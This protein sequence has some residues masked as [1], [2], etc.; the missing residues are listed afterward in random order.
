MVHHFVEQP[1]PDISICAS[2]RARGGNYERGEG[3]F[4]TISV[5]DSYADFDPS[6][7]SALSK[8]AQMA[9]GDFPVA[10]L[11]RYEPSI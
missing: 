5:K 4:L 2:S 9:G 8:I 10:N 6:L 1:L 11:G 3:V 7:Q